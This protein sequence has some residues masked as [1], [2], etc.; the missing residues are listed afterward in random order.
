[1]TAHQPNRLKKLNNSELNCSIFQSVWL[2]GR[3]LRTYFFHIL[4]IMM[5][6]I[7][8]SEVNLFLN[9][10]LEIDKVL[11]AWFQLQTS[12]LVIKYQIYFYKDSCYAVLIKKFKTLTISSITQVLR[13]NHFAILSIF[14]SELEI[15]QEDR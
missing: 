15:Q 6:L 8:Y 2:V 11:T 3:K 4:P 7:S 14:P 5:M 1:M 9:F 12:L 13:I 10:H